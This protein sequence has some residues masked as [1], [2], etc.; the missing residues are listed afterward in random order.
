VPNSFPNGTTIT[1]A[2]GTSGP[3]T[4][5]ISNG[6][7]HDAVAKLLDTS[8]PTPASPKG[9]VIRFVY[10][11]AQS[12][13]TLTGI[14]PGSYVLRFATGTDWDDGAHAFRRDQAF[15]EF[16]DRFDFEITGTF[17]T[18]WS[19]T[20]NPVPGGTATTNSISAAAFGHE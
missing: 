16:D 19:V 5:E 7:S 9:R 6:G 11:R 20:L 3:S 2:I 12:K 15:Y 1:T 14:L 17:Y 13:F 4:L 18:T 10:I 8:N